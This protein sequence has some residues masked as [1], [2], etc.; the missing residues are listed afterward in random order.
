MQIDLVVFLVGL[1]HAVIDV[2]E[3]A[4]NVVGL[5]VDELIFYVANGEKTLKLVHEL[6]VG[7]PIDQVRVLVRI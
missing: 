2:L 7:S 1:V 6:V 5:E 4:V 3:L